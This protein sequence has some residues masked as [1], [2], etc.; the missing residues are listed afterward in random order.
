MGGFEPTTL[1]LKRYDADHLTTAGQ[2]GLDIPNQLAAFE[3]RL[4][5]ADT[6]LQGLT[7]FRHLLHFHSEYHLSVI[8]F[9]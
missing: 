4:S 6:A 3:L 9:I 1:R 2:S 7:A 8:L 5:P